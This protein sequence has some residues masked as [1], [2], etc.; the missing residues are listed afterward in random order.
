VS[1]QV[2]D[3]AIVI[4]PASPPAGTLTYTY[5]FGFTANGGSPPYTWRSSGTVPPGLTV[6]SDGTVSGTPT[7][8]GAFNFSVTATDSAQQ[9]MSS[10][11]LATQIVINI[12]AK[13]TLN[14]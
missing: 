1:L 12:P 10:P 9:P 14:A 11:G 3:S 13:L 2:I 4:A 6:G 5:S 8:V 7:Q